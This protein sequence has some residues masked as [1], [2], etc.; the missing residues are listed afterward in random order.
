M[1]I[2]DSADT[3]IILHFDGSSIVSAQINLLISGLIVSDSSGGSISST[4]SDGSITIGQ[5]VSLTL[6]DTTGDVNETVSVTVDMDNGGIVGGVQFDLFDSPDY[7]TVSNITTTDRTS[8]FTVTMTDI[9]YGTRVLVYDD[10]GNNISAGTGPI[11]NL[12]LTIHSDAYAV[13][14]THLTLPTIC[15]V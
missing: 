5:V 11:L 10:T 12:D 1:C 8:G 9:D 15:S 7:V 3:V 2:R 14:Y 4:G 6:T 13:S